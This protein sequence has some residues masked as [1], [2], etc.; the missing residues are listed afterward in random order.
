M[1][2]LKCENAKLK[3]MVA[4]HLEKVKGM[5]QVAFVGWSK[6]L[7]NLSWDLCCFKTSFVY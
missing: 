1:E 6:L 3:Q 5:S 4:K 2:D 7:A